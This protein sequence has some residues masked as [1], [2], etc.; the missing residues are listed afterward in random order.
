MKQ[1]LIQHGAMSGDMFQIA[2]ALMLDLELRLILVGC[3]GTGQDKSDS[4]YRFYVQDSGISATRIHR[5]T[6]ASESQMEARTKEILKNMHED[7]FH[8]ETTSVGQATNVVA[9]S[10]RAEDA[11]PL[12]R[13]TW[14]R[15]AQ[16]EEGTF[17][18]MVRDW[19]VPL[20]A[21]LVVLWSRQSGALGG[22]HPEHDT[23]YR[24]LELLVERFTGEGYC[25]LIV[26]D[27][28]NG[29]IAGP[30][31]TERYR[32]ACRLGEFWTRAGLVGKPRVYQFAFFEMLRQIVPTLTHVGMRSGNLEAYA[33]M[34]HRVL[35]LE[36]RGR[37]DSV[38]MDK[39]IHADIRLRYASVKL[40]HLPTR[41]GR[42]L[43]EESLRGSVIGAAKGMRNQHKSAAKQNNAG[44]K[45]R[46]QLGKEGLARLAALEDL[47][48]AKLTAFQMDLK[49]FQMMKTAAPTV[50][51]SV[52]K[53]PK[54][55]LKPDLDAIFNTVSAFPKRQHLRGEAQAVP[56]NIPSLR[57]ISFADRDRI[58]LARLA[59]LQT[60]ARV[61]IL[62][63]EDGDRVIGYG[64]ITSED[65]V[66]MTVTFN[67]IIDASA[68]F[69]QRGVESMNFDKGSR[70]IRPR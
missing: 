5:I 65:G 25:C 10:F 49:R 51:D 45:L 66:L 19:K 57:N 68:F 9:A 33:Y 20:L 14:L 3:G 21:P 24:G 62:E 30:L 39:L 29:K 58:G 28:P 36:E 47:E 37:T 18:R 26:G 46:E 44:A 41:T 61:A 13:Q 7:I 38:R 69:F 31:G 12:I 55:F 2:V 54:G 27:D 56:L 53:Q 70:Y 60:G 23:S 59:A 67:E 8:Q 35:F 1:T 22:L 15:N 17:A 64:T 48:K 11:T 16:L 42:F 6:V 34:G 50:K 52:E 40:E 63:P 4:L 32:K 43:M